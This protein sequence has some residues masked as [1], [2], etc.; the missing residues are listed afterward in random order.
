MKPRRLIRSWRGEKRPKEG[1][2]LT[3]IKTY[4][5]QRFTKDKRFGERAMS[6]RCG[7]DI[8]E[9]A[10]IKKVIEKTGKRFI[11]KVFTARES[12]YCES[13]GALKFASY[14]ARFAAK[15]A[16]SKAFGSG[17]GGAASWKE[18]EV[19]NDKKGSPYVELSGN[20]AC[21]FENLGG[22]GISLSLSHCR[23]YAVA[24]VIMEIKAG[25]GGGQS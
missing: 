19:L 11:S 25:R 5:R 21:L 17:I 4:K 2:R 22:E 9:V 6:I 7:V 8:V 10:R 14:A 13:K 16:V 15:E 24:S 20:T 3:K 23:D 12:E 18:I 1:Y